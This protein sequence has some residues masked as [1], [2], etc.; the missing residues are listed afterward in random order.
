MSV[1][2]AGPTDMPHVV[3]TTPQAAKRRAVGELI[4]FAGTNDLHRCQQMCQVWNIDVSAQQGPASARQ[5]MQACYGPR[6]AAAAG[7]SCMCTSS[8]CCLTALK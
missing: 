6:P 8:C 3:Y 7:S 1:S 5:H 2:S 4:F